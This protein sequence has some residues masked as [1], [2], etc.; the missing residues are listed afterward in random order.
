M[1]SLLFA[2]ASVLSPALIIKGQ[3]VWFLTRINL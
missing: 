3:D 2:K 1:K